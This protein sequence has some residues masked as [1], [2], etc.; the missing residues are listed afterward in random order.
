SPDR[1]ILYPGALIQGRSHRDGLGSL[2]PLVIA[3]RAPIRVSIPNL[4]NDDNFREV[5]DV[6][7]ATVDQAVGSM[8]G[9][10]T[11]AELRTPSVITFEQRSYEA[12]AEFALSL[13]LSGRYLGFEASASGEIERSAAETTLTAHYFER[14]YEVVV[15]APQSPG[16]FFSAELTPEL[17]EE[18]VRLGR[19]G[20]DNLPVYV[21][22]VVYGRTFTFSVTSSASEE[23]LRGTVSLAYSGG[24]AELSASQ[25]EILR[26]AKIAVTALGGNAEGVIAAIR[27]GDLKAYF[28]APAPLSS[29]V[30]L[31]YTFKNLSDG[32]IAA[33]TETTEYDLRTCRPSAPGDL[34]EFRPVQSFETSLRTPFTP[35]AGDFDG[36]GRGDL[37]WI[38]RGPSGVELQIGYGEAHG[39]LSLGDVLVF[40]GPD[41]VG[42]GTYGALLVGD[43]DAD[44][45]DDLV[46]NRVDDARNR[47]RVALNEGAEGFRF[48]E[49]QSRRGGWGSYRVFLTDTNADGRDDLVWNSVDPFNRSYVS[50]A[51]VGAPGVFEDAGALDHPLGEGFTRYTT[52]VGDFDGDGRSDLAWSNLN[53]VQNRTYL[54]YSRESGSRTTLAMGSGGFDH[55]SRPRGGW[56]RD[57]ALVGNLDDARG[58]DIVWNALDGHCN[59]F[60]VG[61]ATGMGSAFDAPRR[62]Q[63][64]PA[65]S[66]C[67]GEAEDPSTERW[68]DFTLTLADI[69]AD[70]L[71]DLVWNA[72]TDATNRSYV[73]IANGDGTFDLDF[74]ALDHPDAPGWGRA[75]LLVV[76]VDGDGAD[77]LVWNLPGRQN[78]VYM[79]LGRGLMAP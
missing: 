72:T 33:V 15:A 46:L 3:Q 47:V 5:A 62:A 30:P 20:P 29:A 41:D 27:T 26:E 19:L 13:G 39:A 50:R 43:V 66:G 38:H 8:I 70:G 77:D 74:A 32:S 49:A 78:L 59:R 21:S 69:N 68:D 60:Y 24:A 58:S 34:L 42:W 22:S 67:F 40:D 56:A 65:G 7:Q 61:S 76:D 44:G 18:Q 51:S 64:H 11:R 54:G 57:R 55:P 17:L 53:G 28:E 75:R 10:A 6:S 36:D 2:L 48:L 14:M 1:E 31:S 79:G 71:E 35:H 63:V 73:G 9:A 4:A 52:H 45:L 25:Q 12:E 23:D 16:A 37:L